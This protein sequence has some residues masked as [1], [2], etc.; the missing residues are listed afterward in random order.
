MADENQEQIDLD[1]AQPA[2]PPPSGNELRAELL[3]LVEGDLV[4]PAGGDHEEI[5]ESRVSDRYLSG[6]L[7]PKHRCPDDDSSPGTQSVEENPEEE[8]PDEE[9]SGP[10]SMV[11]AVEATESSI[12]SSGA[13]DPDDGGADGEPAIQTT[14]PSSIGFTCTVDGAVDKLR[15]AASWG[16]YEKVPS[17]HLETDAGKPKKVWRRIPEQAEYVLPLVEGDIKFPA[18]VHFCDAMHEILLEG[19]VRR[20][21]GSDGREVWVATFFL[22]NGQT[23]P[24]ELRDAHW[25][26]QAQL[27]AESVD[28]RGVFV[29]QASGAALDDEAAEMAM[30]YR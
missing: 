30:L 2:V 28:G 9:D 22:V 1:E 13:G 25:L 8:D 4:G 10:S 19:R 7:A 17:D 23:E 21:R 20:Q 5:D 16:R 14:F 11:V 3:R 29:R 6:M 27:T 12:S 15:V 26:F 24:R 18:N